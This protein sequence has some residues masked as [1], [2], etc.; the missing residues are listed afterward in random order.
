MNRNKQMAATLR[1]L[2]QELE[3]TAVIQITRPEFTLLIDSLEYAINQTRESEG[4]K[5]IYTCSGDPYELLDCADTAEYLMSRLI[6]A[7]NAPSG[8]K[9]NINK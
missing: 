3:D 8:I 1:G 2:A 9:L 7:Y 5:H 4:V 6:E